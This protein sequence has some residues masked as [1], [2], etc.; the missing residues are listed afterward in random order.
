MAAIAL[1]RVSK[2]YPTGQTA[3]RD[4]TLEIVNG[5][6]LVLLGPSGS[7]KSTVL[8][9][10]AGLETPTSGQ[11]LI[12]G[13]DVTLV[14]PPRRD[15]AMV[16]Q[17]YALYPHK[18]VRENL[19]FGLRVRGVDAAR[20][21]ARVRET[22]TALDI[23]ALL[24]RRPAQLSGGQRQRVALGRAIVRE[25][26]AFLFDEPL[27][28]LDPTLR[29]GTRTEL[30]LLHRRLATTMV[31]VTHD[32]EEAM[33]LGT[34]V[35]VMR[36]GAIEQVA[37][38]LEVFR[39][40]ANTFVARFIGS[41]AMNLWACTCAR[42]GDGR[43]LVSPAFSID[44]TGIDVAVPDGAGVYVGV[45]PHDIDIVPN[46][47]GNGAGGVEIVEPLGPVTVVHLR[48]GGLGD[49]FVRVVVPADS[50]IEVG[51]RVTFRVRP[52]RLHVFDAR[53][54]QRVIDQ[55]GR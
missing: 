35:A 23:E 31:Y 13:R 6:L 22:A 40:P 5:E 7:G 8:R 39:R 33:T 2:V 48:V 42:V 18:S 16:F 25:P 43:H 47:E 15:L 14:P 44:L 32:Q 1:K 52:D 11:V 51:D 26:K 55:H 12:D 37:P 36:A 29:A 34:R 27:S 53:T 17:S 38:A 20:V 46:G 9:L 28:N 21:D 10:I 50:R 49:D 24:E 41:P 45:R 3:V 19:A 54:G 30:A 4:L